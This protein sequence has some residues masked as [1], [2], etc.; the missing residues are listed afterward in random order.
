M[1]RFGTAYGIRGWLKVISFTDPIDNLL[2][3]KTWHIHHNQEWQT[4]VIEAGKRHGQFLVVKIADC[5]DRDQA[6]TFTNDLIAVPRDELTPLKHGEYYWT[7]LVG[8]RVL[9]QKGIEL[10]KI[11]HLIET[12]SNDVMIVKDADTERLVPYTNN[13]VKSINLDS[14]EMH[15]DWDEDF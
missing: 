14:Q 9:N 7:D 15:V 5:E 3:Y 6:L 12:G 10:G 13:V 1:G 8:L 2:D 4:V 11:D